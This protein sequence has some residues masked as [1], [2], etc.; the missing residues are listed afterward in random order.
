MR[1]ASLAAARGNPPSGQADQAD[2]R[3]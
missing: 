3:R 2:I 1:R